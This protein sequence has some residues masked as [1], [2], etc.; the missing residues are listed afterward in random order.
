MSDLPKGWTTGSLSETLRCIESGGRPKGGVKGISSGVPSIGGEHL[1]SN[2]R[3]NF[4]SIRYVPREFARKMTK[5]HIKK[6]DILIVKDGAT[7]GKT[8]FV[9]N[10]F[11]FDE[12]VINEHVFICRLFEEVEPRFV[13][14]FLTSKDGQEQILDNF[15]GSAQGGI[16]LSFASNTT[17]PLAP[18]NEQRRIVEKL[19][20]LLQKVDVCKERLDKIPAILKRFRQSVLAA[21]CSGRLTTDW[22]KKNPDIEPAIELLKKI[23]T[24]RTNTRGMPDFVDFPQI[25]SSWEYVTIG[26]ITNSIKYGTSVKCNYEK[27]GVPVLR[28][29]NISNGVVDIADLKYAD[30]PASEYNQL[31]LLE[32][33]IL[34]IRSNGS[35][36]LVGK[37]AIIRNNESAF[38][39]AGYLIR[40]RFD[41]RYINPYYVNFVLSTSYTRDQI[42]I[43][44]RSTSGVHNINSEEIKR[45]LISLPPLPE[46]Q[47]IVRQVGALFKKAEEVEARYKKAKDFVDRLT[48][49]ILAKAFRGELVPQDPND[50]PAPRPGKWFIYALECE[51]GSIYIGQTHDIERRWKDHASGRGAEWTKKH[52]PKCLVHWEVFESLES[53]VAREQELKTGFGRKWLKREYAAGR[54]RQAGEPASVLLERIKAEKARMKESQKKE[55]KRKRSSK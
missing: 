11:P 54:T 27:I 44:A 36:S 51:D 21:A 42:E 31:K 17:I 12:A 15:Q 14:R 40:L 19:E 1:M 48:Q 33:D 2:G 50:L 49:S 30:L 4:S 5:G 9:G 45:L 22:R 13:F 10:D 35:V 55:T 47:E 53:A 37:S 8:A 7:T 46:Q 16:N 6:N 20:K 28:I 52:L 34:M 24:E 41:N 23:Q 3:F 25:P 18:L 29:P 38:A 26:R 43:P 32:G 39:Y